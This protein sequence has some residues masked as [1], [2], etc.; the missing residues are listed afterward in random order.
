MIKKHLYIVIILAIVTSIFI[1]Y[2]AV[3]PK[4]N[5]FV[6]VGNMNVARAGHAA[7]LLADGNV[8]ITGGYSSINKSSI[9]K[10]AEIYNVTTKKFTKISNMNYPRFSH[11]TILLPNR[12]V[13]ILGGEQDKKLPAEMYDPRTMEFKIV[14]T[15]V[16]C[17]NAYSS[18]L[19][20]DNKIL[21]NGFVNSKPSFNFI[22][23]YDTKSN[24]CRLINK[25]KSSDP[26][27]QAFLL[28]NG[29]IAFFKAIS[30]HFSIYDLKSNSFKDK[31]LF[32]KCDADGFIQLQQNKLFG[33]CNI[34]DNESY[35][36]VCNPIT[37]ICNI[38]GKMINAKT[39]LGGVRITLLQDGN[40]LI[41]GGKQ[42][43]RPFNDRVTNKSE[44]YDPIKGKSLKSSKMSKPRKGHS[45]TLLNDGSVLIVGGV[46]DESIGYLN[47]VELYINDEP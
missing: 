18:V 41:T 36:E 3:R 34:N 37:N 11:N 5:E 14:E 20:K 2:K 28:S 31:R 29:K 17:S 25:T 44:I 47:S 16:D 46:K 42:G 8:L 27:G 39:P 35:G 9:T 15:S 23:L 1:L 19:L 40:I 4:N 6:R 26:L 45:S 21:I 33:I 22:S 38:K 12:K 10:T 30:Q 7:T 13:L 32:N 24:S 43:L